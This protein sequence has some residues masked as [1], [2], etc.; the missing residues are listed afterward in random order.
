M[1]PSSSAFSGN[2]A[3]RVSVELSYDANFKWHMPICEEIWS[4]DTY[5]NDEMLQSGFSPFRV[6]D[7]FFQNSMVDRGHGPIFWILFPKAVICATGWYR[8]DRLKYKTLIPHFSQEVTSFVHVGHLLWF[9][10][11]EKLS[12][13]LPNRQS[14]QNKNCL[15]SI[16]SFYENIIILKYLLFD[17]IL[18]WWDSCIFSSE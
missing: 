15:D 8:C 5:T 11:D 17:L 2:Y 6:S 13:A 10:I 12:F 16:W 7:F 18:I 9:K 1:G 3:D 4:T 14:N